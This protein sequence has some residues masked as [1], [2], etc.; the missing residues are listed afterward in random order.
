MWCLYELLLERNIPVI[1]DSSEKRYLKI[2]LG[3]AEIT[4]E[5][6]PPYCDRGNFVVKVFSQDSLALSIDRDDAFPR[7]YFGPAACAD[8]V[9]AWVEARN[10]LQYVM[11]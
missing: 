8:E 3:P 10:L 7:Y 2:D 4:I 11:G 1:W 9:V 5:S 6:R